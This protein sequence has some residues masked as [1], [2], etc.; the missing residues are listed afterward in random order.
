MDK[1][2][3]LLERLVEATEEIAANLN[4]ISA[5]IDMVVDGSDIRKPAF[6]RTANVND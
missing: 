2:F 1:W 3:E 5:N 6:I 4:L